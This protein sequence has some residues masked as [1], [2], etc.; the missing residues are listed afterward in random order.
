MRR[1]RPGRGLSAKI[2]LLTIAFVLL[3]E[4]LIFVPSVARFRLDFLE[5]RI[6]SAHLAALT[7]RP[8]IA[9]ALDMDAADA[10]LQ[11]AGVSSIVVK[12][13]DQ[14]L[15]LGQTS[16]IVHAFF[17]IH[18]PTWHGL[19]IDAFET[20]AA[21][22]ERMIRVV[23]PS[24]QEAGTEVQIIMPEAPL[25]FAMVGYSVRIL[26]LSV[27]LSLLVAGAIFLALQHLFVQPL[28]R[29]TEELAT[30]RDH[31]EAQVAESAPSTRGDEIGIVERE[32]AEMRTAL[33]RSL[34]EKTRLAALGA[35]MTQVSHDLRNILAS[36]VLISD[37]LEASNDPAV[38]RV[39]P[40]LVDTLERAARLCSE[41]LSYAR[42]GPP[43]PKPERTNLMALLRDVEA[44]ADGRQAG[45]V[46]RVEVPPE[47]DVNVDRDQLHRVL[48]NLA[49]NAREAMGPSG[50]FTVSSEVT[51]DA[52]RI[53]LADTGPGI[54]EKLRQRLFQ[55]F[56][57][58][59]KPTG[60]GLGLAICRELMRAHGGD[61]ELLRTSPQGT[62]FRLSLP[63]RLIL[64]P[65]GARRKPMPLETVGRS[66]L[67]LLLLLAACG[68][69]GPGIRGYTQPGLQ[70]EVVSFYER[71]AMEAGATC[72]QPRMV[73]VRATVIEETP[74]Q[75]VM[76]IRYRW[77]DEA[78]LDT[79]WDDGMLRPMPALQR[80][81]GWNERTFTFA[82]RTDG[83]L[84]VTSMTGPQRRP[85]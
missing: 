23:G 67:P 1:P 14:E 73:P 35:A 22:G 28:R 44:E 7:V 40:R 26:T 31:P 56:A 15:M 48:A 30:F 49:Q 12:A 65:R 72:P 83:S 64:Q 38:R 47:L 58:S 4:V 24:P 45:I 43:A 81:N 51:A 36:A 75:V 8:E 37:R 21:R 57:A 10:L 78:Q 32:L 3:G 25:W 68:V 76:N 59:S 50:T 34:V 39:A 70:W 53:D 63:A 11:H 33:R 20:L 79:D 41:T 74:E 17:D 80:C 82:K 19:I 77:T 42:T 46:W 66:A 84:Q 5:K 6:A 60:S 85:T 16:P 13:A 61:V 54:P 52:L 29:I 2:L 27:I 71:Y 9:D 69:Q 55:P 18:Q 62:V